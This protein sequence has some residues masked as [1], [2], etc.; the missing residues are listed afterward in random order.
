MGKTILMIGILIAS[1]LAGCRKSNPEPE[2]IILGELAVDLNANENVVRK[3]EAKYGN[4]VCDAIDYYINYKGYAFDFV[5]YNGGGLRFNPE[6]RPDGIYHAGKLSNVD[7]DEMLP[8]GNAHVI[9]TMTG[10]EIK[11]M[12][13]RGIAQYPLA[14]GPFLQLSNQVE[15]TYDTLAQPQLLNIDQTAISTPGARVTGI[16]IEGIDIDPIAE[17]RVIVNNFLAEG[18]DGFVVF[19][20]IPD[21]KKEYIDGYEVNA[22]KEYVQ[23]Y[24]PVIV[25]LTNRIIFN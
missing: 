23:V 7:L 14:K 8:F 17:Y 11:I 19:N 18:N 2:E 1:L 5:V 25:D 21:A 6:S 3:R 9:V 16:K 20:S 12:F 4:F 22:L 13:E 24:S 10:E 15:V